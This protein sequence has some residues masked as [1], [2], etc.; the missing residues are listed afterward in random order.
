MRQ[1]IFMLKGSELI[2]RDDRKVHSDKMQDIS[3]RTDGRTRRFSLKKDHKGLT[4]VFL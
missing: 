3:K 1:E 2:G 4:H